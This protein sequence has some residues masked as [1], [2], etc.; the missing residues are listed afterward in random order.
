MICNQTKKTTALYGYKYSYPVLVNV[1]KIMWFEVW[2]KPGC[3]GYKEVIHSSQS[4]T[5]EYGLVKY[6]FLEGSVRCILSATNK[7]SVKEWKMYP[8]QCWSGSNSK[9]G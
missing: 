5:P 3:N 6:T 7:A 4:L 1:H 8:G 9:E 2:G